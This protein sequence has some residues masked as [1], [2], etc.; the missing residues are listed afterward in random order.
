M[1]KTAQ[2]KPNLYLVGFMGVGKSAIGRRVARELGLRFIDSDDQIEREQGRKIPELFASKGEA[3]FRKLERQFIEHGHA[4]RGC[5]VSCGGG[6][7]VQEGMKELLKQKGV[8]ICLF[9]SAESIIE[10]TS[11]N[12]NRPLL[13][14]PNPEEKV[15]ALLAEREPIY[16]DSGACITTEG[17]TIPEV[18]RHMIRTYKSIARNFGK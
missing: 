14:V 12:K 11:R 17:R 9:A 16:M 1:S 8:V 15:R 2:S 13:N 5:V 3:Y 6:L 7:V 10:R 18:V 4:D